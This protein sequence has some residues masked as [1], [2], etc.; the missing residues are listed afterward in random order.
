MT[1][2]SKRKPYYRAFLCGVAAVWVCVLS[3][4]SV[5]AEENGTAE[6]TPASTP[7]S[8]PQ[9]E[10]AD[11]NAPPSTPA[12]EETRPADPNQPA[13]D[14]NGGSMLPNEGD[15]AEL[16]RYLGLVFNEGFVSAEGM[17]DYGSLR[18]K[19]SDLFNAVR[20]LEN[21]HPAVLMSMGREERIA[22]WI[23]TY[24]TCT[25]KLIIDNY[26]IQPKW[27][28]ILYPNNSVMQKIGR[29]SCRVRV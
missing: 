12:P 6:N 11:P 3:L 28:M 24:N 8:A 29:A 26:P 5:N 23:N 21:L 19:R 1:E 22:F 13:N 10:P 4:Q 16:Y 7:A 17:V 14:E 18:R 2:I 20:I 15:V 25:L 9:N 27:Y